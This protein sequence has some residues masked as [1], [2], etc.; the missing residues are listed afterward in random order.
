[1]PWSR[2]MITSGFPYPSVP[3]TT[4]LIYILTQTPHLG[5][6]TWTSINPH[7]VPLVNTRQI[8]QLGHHTQPQTSDPIG[9]H[10]P[11]RNLL[12]LSLSLFTIWHI[13]FT[14]FLVILDIY[15]IDTL[16]CW[17]FRVLGP[18]V[19]DKGLGF[20]LVLSAACN[21]HVKMYKQTNY[22]IRNSHN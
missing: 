10:T 17:I 11:P 22:H 14:S 4:P 15:P 8:L 20:M 12:S 18:R 21:K 16:L 13:T 1:M 2:L 3:C 5:P 7:F 6:C 19:D 9:S